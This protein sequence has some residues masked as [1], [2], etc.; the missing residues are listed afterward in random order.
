VDICAAVDL[1]GEMV[2]VPAEELPQG[3]IVVE[4]RDLGPSQSQMT[5]SESQ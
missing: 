5:S 2:G 3:Y 1:L 4:C